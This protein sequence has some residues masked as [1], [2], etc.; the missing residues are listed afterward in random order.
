MSIKF[1]TING[2]LCRMVEPTPLTEK[3]LTHYTPC[4]IRPIK[5]NTQIGKL[6][7]RTI[8]SGLSNSDGV[9]ILNERQI[10]TGSYKNMI[11]APWGS[12]HAF[13]QFEIIGY[14]VVEG[15]AEWALYQMMQGKKVSYKSAVGNVYWELNQ[16]GDVQ[17]YDMSDLAYIGTIRSKLEFVRCYAKTIWQIYTEPE[18]EPKFKVGDWVET[19]IGF[20]QV[21]VTEIKPDGSYWSGDYKLD[22][23]TRKLDPSE[24]IVRIGCLSGTVSSRDNKSFHLLRKGKNTMV[25]YLDAL[26]APTLEL[27]EA[28]L[29]AQEEK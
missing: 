29:K 18:P 19:E 28:L 1:E 15:S 14:P 25:I 21:K 5:D 7:K 17:Y 12:A 26:D 24:V 22:K 16:N 27:V 2:Q 20:S 8:Y 23:I 10:G 13:E 11:Y 3:S 9:Y 4:A 6:N